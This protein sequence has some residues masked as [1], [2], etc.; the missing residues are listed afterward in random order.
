MLLR[1][2]A[3]NS[4][5]DN[6]A[7]G[8]IMAELFTLRPLFPGASEADQIYKICSVLGSPSARTWPDG[9]KLAAAMNFRFPQVRTGPRPAAFVPV[10]A[11]MLTTLQN[12]SLYLHHW[13]H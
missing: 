12:R 1:S 4:P 2:P 3:Y 7:C 11:D 9:L 13:R 8:C 10:F 5:V 6:F